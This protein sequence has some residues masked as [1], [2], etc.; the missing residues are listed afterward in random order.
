MVLLRVFCVVLRR[1]YFLFIKKYC[2]RAGSS[3]SER[4][5]LD[6]VVKWAGGG[7]ACLVDDSFV[8]KN[9]GVAAKCVAGVA[10][11]AVEVVVDLDIVAFLSSVIGIRQVVT[12]RSK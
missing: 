10:K 9:V 2:I 8:S 11:W 4:F 12:T 1:P 3:P 5:E 6:V 7:G